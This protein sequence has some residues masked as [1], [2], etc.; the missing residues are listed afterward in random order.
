VTVGRP[1]SDDPNAT[2]AVSGGG[3]DETVVVRPAP[4]GSESDETMVV[5]AGGPVAEPASDAAGAV[6]ATR[7]ADA[8][9]EEEE[10][11]VEVLEDVT[12]NRARAADDDEPPQVGSKP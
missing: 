5:P 1:G 2:M 10:T 9:A 7:D 6:S 11:P 8:D 12:G 3:P 4:A